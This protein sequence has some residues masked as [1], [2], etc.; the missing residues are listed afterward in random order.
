MAKLRTQSRRR[1]AKKSP[2]ILFDKY[3][4]Y[5]KAVQSVDADVEF[6]ENAYKELKKKKPQVLREDFCGTFALSCEWVKTRPHYQA[7]AV[8]IDPEPMEYGRL[9]Y[10]D[11][12]QPAQ[13]KRLKLQEQNVLTPGLPAAD[14]SVACN[15]SYFLFK[16][17]PLLKKYFENVYRG[18]KKDGLFVCDVFGGSQCHDTVEDKIK[19]KGFTYY[20][21]Q[22]N[23][24][25]VTNEAL[26][27]IHF[28]FKG[29][30]IEKVFTYDWRLWSIPELRELLQEVGFAK[31]HI[32]WEGTTRKG[33]GNGVFSRTEQGEPCESWICYLVA[34]K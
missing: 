11:R 29:K 17:R 31:T 30:K 22:T 21:D 27:Y 6:L 7:I 4:L 19:L 20:W 26:F 24:D 15:F 33:E 8:D 25:P 28:R 32:Y 34:E 12:L 3:D 9:H 23:F 1:V 2:K 13:Q 18:L 10:L 14:I 5:K 16:T